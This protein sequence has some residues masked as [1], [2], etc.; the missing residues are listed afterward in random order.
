MVPHLSE[1]A[2]ERG[3]TLQEADEPI[4]WVF[5]PHSG[6]IALVVIGP[7]GQAVETAVIGR[8]GALNLNAALGSQIALGCAVVQMPGQ[9]AR[10]PAVRL[11]KLA[12]DSKALRAFIAGF[13]DALLAQT[14]QSAMCFAR[15]GV[16]A[17]LA[18]WLLHAREHAGSDVLRITQEAVAEALGVR[19]TTV[20]LIMQVLQQRGV[21]R[22]SRG[23]IHIE[24]VAG[25]EAD[26]CDCYPIVG[27][28]TDGFWAKAEPR[29]N[30]AARLNR[31]PRP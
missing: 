26:A 5:F 27:R 31:P 20:T 29:S 17:R 2:L 8:D 25:L 28:L 3:R 16:E 14:Q 6:A 30:R 13:Q 12:D 24:D 7:H 23:T 11:R 18:R 4:D 22:C 1:V 9:A 19:R 21:A 10:I 15:H